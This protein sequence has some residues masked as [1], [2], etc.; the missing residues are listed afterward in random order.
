[1]SL[2]DHIT[3]IDGQ[4]DPSALSMPTRRRRV[5]GDVCAIFVHAGAGFHSVQN[6][7]I[8]LKACEE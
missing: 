4:V 1:M 3:Q 8:H 2:D 6:E 5:G 7:R